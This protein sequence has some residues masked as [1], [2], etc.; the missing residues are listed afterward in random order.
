M[1]RNEKAWLGVGILVGLLIAGGAYLYFGTA[2]AV[3]DRSGGDK[4]PEPGEF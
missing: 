2:R 3:G 1:R 4:P